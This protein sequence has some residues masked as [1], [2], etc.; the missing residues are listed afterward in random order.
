MHRRDPG[1]HRICRLPGRRD[2][3]T[4]EPH[5]AR[6]RRRRVRGRVGGRGGGAARARRAG[7]MEVGVVHVRRRFHFGV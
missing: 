1:P 7:G 3:P 2:I 6:R 5:V 4:P